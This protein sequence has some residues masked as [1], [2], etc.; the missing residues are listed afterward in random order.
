[1]NAPE[2]LP[3]ADLGVDTEGVPMCGSCETAPATRRA[4]LR[5]CRHSS[6]V[7]EACARAAWEFL[8][9]NESYCLT[10]KADVLSIE[11]RPL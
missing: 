10:C 5:P 11:W 7:C 1:M 3:K 2:S 8:N 4:S 9:R 6:L